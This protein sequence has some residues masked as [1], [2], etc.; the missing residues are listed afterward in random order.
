MRNGVM[1]MAAAA[2]GALLYTHGDVNTLVVMY[3][4]NVFVTFSLSMFAMARHV[5][6]TRGARAHWKKRMTVFVVGF[7][8]CFTI[9]CI[10]VVEKF[11]QGGYVT[12]FVTGAVVIACMVI[13]RHY[14]TVFAHLRK[15]YATLEDLPL[16]HKGPVPAVDPSRPPRR[17]TSRCAISTA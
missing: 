16:T 6:K 2:M 5:H 10:T 15:L 3:S 4:I 12:L 17:S 1:I 14:R 11:P 9:L 7:A 13:N 8:L